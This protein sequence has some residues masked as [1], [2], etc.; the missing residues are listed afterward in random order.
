MTDTP[1]NAHS[2]PRPMISSL[3]SVT[4]LPARF[5][6]RLQHLLEVFNLLRLLAKEVHKHGPNKRAVIA[7]ITSA[8]RTPPSIAIQ[9]NVP[10]ITGVQTAAPCNSRA[11]S[12]RPSAV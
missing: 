2:A 12:F 4:M 8:P 3:W 7:D 6:R 11:C 1:T 5:A 10:T 9:M